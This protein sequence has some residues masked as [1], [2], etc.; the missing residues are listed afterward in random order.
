[1]NKGPRIN[2]HKC[3]HYFIT[4]E[5]NHPYGCKFFNFKSKHLPSLVVFQSSGESCLKFEKRI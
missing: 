2:C 3:K 1:M 4:W 5:P